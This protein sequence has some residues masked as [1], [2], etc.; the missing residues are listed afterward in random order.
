MEFG[1]TV[2]EVKSWKMRKIKEYTTFIQKY[3]EKKYGSEEDMDM[4]DTGRMP[5]TGKIPGNIK[6]QAKSQMPSMSSSHGAGGH[7]F[8]F[9]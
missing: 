4:P 8:K 3:Y 5:K 2:E 9:K 1:I 6:R 7:N